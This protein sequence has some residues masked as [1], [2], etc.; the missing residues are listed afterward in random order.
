MPINR[1]I[2]D[3]EIEAERAAIL[4]R[5]FEYALR[6]LGLVDRADALT[7][8]VAERV[9]EVSATGISDPEEIARA[10][11]RRLGLPNTR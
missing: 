8:I 5:A 7:G 9:V 4:N 6:E 1:L 11:I 10:A 2:K 3:R